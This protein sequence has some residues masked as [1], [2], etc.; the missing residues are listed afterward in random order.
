MQEKFEDFSHITPEIILSA[1]EK[2]DVKCTGRIIPL[3]SL[4]NRV[5]EVELEIKDESKIKSKYE[6]SRVIKFYRPNRWTKDQILE[7]H[8]FIFDL[9]NQ[10]IPVV[11][12]I[13]F[14]NGQSLQTI[15]DATRDNQEIYFAVYPKVGGRIIDEFSDSQIA[16]LGRLI[17]RMHLVA[18]QEKA[19]H[20]LTLNPSTY[21]RANLQYLITSNILP[22]EITERYSYLVNTICD[23]TD[24]WIEGVSLQRVHGDF[25]IG[26]ILWANDECQLVDFDD[27]VMAPAIQDLW[28]IV[29][30]RDEWNL[31]QREVLLNAY[32]SMINFDFDTIRLIEPF[33][34][35]RLINFTTWVAKRWEDAS[36]KNIFVD[37]NSPQYW[38]EQL[39]SLEEVLQIMYSGEVL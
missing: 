37:F 6:L 7:E 22:S 39:I 15:N 5:Y 19:K 36:F 21:G 1:V 12:P 9:K 34:A 24:S 2:L 38:R 33:R 3:N 10:E 4:E 26:N 20:R 35:L 17:A 30:G 27:F 8:K 16:L 29:S 18:R 31:K 14:E 28:L 32:S 11:S 13:V 23:I 25:H